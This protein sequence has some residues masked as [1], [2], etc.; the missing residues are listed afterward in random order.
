[1]VSQRD[2]VYLAFESGGSG[3]GIGNCTQTCNSSVKEVVYRFPGH[4]HWDLL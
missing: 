2:T 4:T 3:T 1:M